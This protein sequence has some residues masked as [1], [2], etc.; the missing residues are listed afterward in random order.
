MVV[1]TTMMMVTAQSL[2]QILHI[3]K[4]AVLRSARKVAGQL[5]QLVGRVGI[6]IRLR[7]LGGGLQIRRDLLSDL[8]VLT[9]IRLLKLLERAHDLDEW[10]KLTIVGLLRR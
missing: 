2:R 10:R 7:G 3:W 1:M 8:L 9:R 5:V 4:L 6:S